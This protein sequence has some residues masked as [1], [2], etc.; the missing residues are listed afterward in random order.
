MSNSGALIQ[1]SCVVPDQSNQCS[2]KKMGRQQNRCS[3]K[4]WICQYVSVFE[5]SSLLRVFFPDT[6]LKISTGKQEF[7]MLAHPLGHQ[8][9]RCFHQMQICLLTQTDLFLV[10][11]SLCRIGLR[12]PDTVQFYQLQLNTQFNNWKAFSRL[13]ARIQ[14]FA[15]HSLCIWLWEDQ[16]SVWTHHFLT[17]T[18][19]RRRVKQCCAVCASLET[20]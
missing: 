9:F 15:C 10:A 1:L 12:G 19:K 4:L 6:A 18:Q 5:I 14:V 11:S 7:T 8:M 13:N 17:K 3:P 2:F 20:S 16:I